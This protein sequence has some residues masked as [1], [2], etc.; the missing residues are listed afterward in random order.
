[1][2]NKWRCTPPHT[3]PWFR[4]LAPHITE[5]H[6]KPV[7]LQPGRRGEG[8]HPQGQEEPGG[9]Q[10]MGTLRTPCCRDHPSTERQVPGRALPGTG[11]CSLQPAAPRAA[12]TGHRDTSW[13][14][15]A[16]PVHPRAGTVAPVNPWAGTAA[17]SWNPG[18]GA[19]TGWNC[20][21]GASMGWRRGPGASSARAAAPQV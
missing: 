15:T 16:A 5:P 21:P 12:S 8:Q 9:P 7:P 18:P 2:P 4:R 17:L 1:M 19:S 20:S 14:G 13:A 3:F 10:R 11:T 6:G